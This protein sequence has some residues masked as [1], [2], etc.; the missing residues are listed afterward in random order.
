MQVV[1]FININC[2]L[3]HG[4]S[5]QANSKE[6]SILNQQLCDSSS[7]NALQSQP[8]SVSK[9]PPR[10]YIAS[11]TSDA[12]PEKDY[13]AQLWCTH[14]PLLRPTL[15]TS[16][17]LEKVNKGD[18]SMCRPAASEDECFMDQKAA[19][20]T[21]IISTK[22][23][24]NICLL[25]SLPIYSA[26]ADSPIKTKESFKSIY[27]E[28]RVQRL[29][30][31][32]HTKKK[33]FKSDG[34]SIALGF[35]APPYP[36]WRL[37]GWQRGSIAVHGDDGRCYIND[38]CGGIDFTS[39]FSVGETVGVGM[40]FIEAEGSSGSNNLP[41]HEAF[42]SEK[43]SM[44]VHY[45]LTKNGQKVV[46]WNLYEQFDARP[47]S[48]IESRVVGLEGEHDLFIA[49]GIYGLV[50]CEVIVRPDDLLFRPR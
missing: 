41:R 11:S 5:S 33:W 50:E 32:S 17:I 20:V 10:S 36:C 16:S 29:G 48:G 38:P 9:L 40:T 44:S 39:P 28:V 12:S 49:L 43:S 22:A 7:T 46:E 23:C 24:Q 13:Q 2:T 3:K 25:S 35:T 26:L 19:G 18:Y 30:S 4:T 6:T 1:D 14:N 42:S 31:H 8:S 27:Y 21:R 34:Y 45:F 37:P 15:L 47:S